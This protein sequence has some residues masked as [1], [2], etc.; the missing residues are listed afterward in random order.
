AYTFLK[1]R[2]FNALKEPQF[3]FCLLSWLVTQD[4][5]SLYLQH[6][7]KRKVLLSILPHRSGWP[8]LR[9]PATGLRRHRG[10]RRALQAR[11]ASPL[12]HRRRGDGDQARRLQASVRRPDGAEAQQGVDAAQAMKRP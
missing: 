5:P 6:V 7:P 12:R 10:A 2:F 11:L 1:Q 4:P 3:A 8:W 9:C